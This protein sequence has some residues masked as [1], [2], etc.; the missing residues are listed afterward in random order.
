MFADDIGLCSEMS[1]T[2]LEKRRMKVSKSK[3]QYMA[4][5]KMIAG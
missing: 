3:T 4:M 2:G 1:K 5:N